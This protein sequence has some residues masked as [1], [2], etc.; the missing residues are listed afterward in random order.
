M[1]GATDLSSFENMT[2]AQQSLANLGSFYV[3]P[4]KPI[5]GRICMPTS[6][7]EMASVQKVM[8]DSAFADYMG[9]VWDV[10]SVIGFVSVCALIIGFLFMLLMRYF[11]GVLVWLCIILYF[12]ALILMTWSTW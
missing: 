2:E 7:V 11:V 6:L 1:A 8:P 9:D 12:V 5:Y 3:Y 10:R 4:T